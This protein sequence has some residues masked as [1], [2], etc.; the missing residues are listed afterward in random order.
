M[1]R[2]WISGRN[3]RQRFAG[4]GFLRCDAL[5]HAITQ[6]VL[7]RSRELTAQLGNRISMQADG[8]A[9]TEDATDEVVVSLVEFDS[10]R[11]VFVIHRVHGVTRS[12][13][14]GAGL[15]T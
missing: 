3:S 2:L 11:I 9:Q 1:A 10:S 14:A 5:F 7:Y 12:G 15:R 13:D 8:A 6:T 4:S